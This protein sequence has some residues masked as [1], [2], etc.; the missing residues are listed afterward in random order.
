MRNDRGFTL[1]EVLIAVAFAGASLGLIFEL[2][3]NAINAVEISRDMTQA[4]VLARQK[5]EEAIAMPLAERKDEGDFEGKFSGY[6]WQVEVSSQGDTIAA[7]R[8]EEAKAIIG[9]F[10]ILVRVSW[11]TKGR[12]HN[13]EMATLKTKVD[14]KSEG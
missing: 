7:D 8:Q 3:C 1:I 12:T 4:T 13:I 5:M 11:E 14:K 2:F 6:H 9:M 10:Q